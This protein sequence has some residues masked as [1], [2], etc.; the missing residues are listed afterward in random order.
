MDTY[1]PQSLASQ[2]FAEACKVLSAEVQAIKERINEASKANAP[3]ASVAELLV[4]Y[5][6]T[7]RCEE[8]IL[9]GFGQVMHKQMRELAQQ[10]NI[11]GGE[12]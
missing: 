9:R 6:Q 3:D 4:R 1:E 8:L 2:M 7:T 5:E 12:A 10:A 11:I